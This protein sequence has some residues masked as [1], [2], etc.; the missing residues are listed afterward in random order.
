MSNPDNLLTSRPQAPLT[1]GKTLGSGVR[2]HVYDSVSPENGRACSFP[3]FST[4][5]R[6][7]SR[8]KREAGASVQTPQF[9]HP[10]SACLLVVF[11]SRRRRPRLPPLT[12]LSGLT[13]RTDAASGAERPGAL[14]PHHAPI[15][16]SSAGAPR[17]ASRLSARLLSGSP[18]RFISSGTAYSRNYNRGTFPAVASPPCACSQTWKMVRLQQAVLEGLRTVSWAQVGTF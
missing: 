8:G 11:Q 1:T 5:P 16:A 7:C 12:D 2:V 13:R 10:F 18:D 4:I 15:A 3:T 9:L 14:R 6:N 17:T